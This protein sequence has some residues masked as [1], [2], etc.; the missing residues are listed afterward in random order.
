[1]RLSLLDGIVVLLDSRLSSFG[2]ELAGSVKNSRSSEVPVVDELRSIW[3]QGDCRHLGEKGAAF[4]VAMS[5]EPGGN[6]VEIAV[7]VAGMAAEF[8]GSIGGYGVEDLVEGFAVE[9]AGSR[10]ADGSV[11]GGDVRA[12]DLGL[13]FK[14]S[15]ETA[16]EFHLKTTNAI[17]VAKSKAPGLLERVTNGANG[18]AFG[19]SQKWAGYGREEMGV[20]VGID[21]SDGDASTLEFLHLG[22]GL[23]FDI[24]FADGASQQSLNEVYERGAKALAIAANETGDTV[25]RRDGDAVGK[26]DV[27]AHAEGGIGVGDGDGVIECVAGGHQRG[28]GERFGLMELRDGTVDTGSEAEVVRV[29]DESG[30]HKF[31]T[32]RSVS[33]QSRMCRRS[34]CDF[35]WRVE[36][37]EERQICVCRQSRTAV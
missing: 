28:G 18:A 32:S 21:V 7:V 11:G 30:R 10:D 27:A 31:F 19:D 16:E 15:F 1:L 23:A 24:V 13:M 35:S 17:A 29:D 33:L 3:M 20:F 2:D 4:D 6:A 36:A 8:E 34:K 26:D 14:V 22:G 9:V 25:R 5:T 12:T 37:P